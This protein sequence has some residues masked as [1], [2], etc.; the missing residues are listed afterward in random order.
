MDGWMDG[1]LVFI[2]TLT[3]LVLLVPSYSWTRKSRAVI[4]GG[5]TPRSIDA[6]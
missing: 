4:E 5:A 6:V 3:K 1:W 2:A